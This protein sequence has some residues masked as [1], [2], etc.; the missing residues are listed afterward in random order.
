M[1]KILL[2][3]FFCGLL[4]LYSFPVFAQDKTI[5]GQVTGDGNKPLSDVTVTVKGTSA[6]TKTDANGYY[7]IKAPANAT[8]VFTFVD[9]QRSE[10]NV[11][12]RTTVNAAMTA[13]K[14]QM[15][16]VVVTALGISRN[17][18]ALASSSQTVSGTDLAESQ[19]ENVLTALAG[20]VAGVNITTT[21]GMPGASTG[22]ILRGAVS[23]DGNNQPLIIIDGLPTDN[24]TFSQ[25]NLVSDGP[26]RNND[27]TNRLADL[28]PNDIESITVLKGPEAT[29]L[30]G[31]GGA[32]GALI[33]TTRKAKAGKAALNYDY[34]FRGEKVYRFA[35]I[36]K[37]YGRGS[38]NVA[39]PLVRTFFGPKY[40]DTTKLYDN[41]EDF[42]K[43]G[44]TNKHNMSVE[45]G[46]EKISYRFS[47]NVINQEG[48][49]RETGYDRYS[50][51]L[52]GNAILSP[53]VE[54][55][56][57]LNY[58]NTKNA[59]ATK[60]QFGFL[61]G[62]YTWP[63][64][65]DVKNFLNPDGT[66]N[67]I[68]D[69]SA[70]EIDNP[71]WDA[72][73]NRSE[74][75]NNRFLGNTNLTYKAT[76]WLTLKSTIGIDQYTTNGFTVTHPQSRNGITPKGQL[77]N[78][79]EISRLIS[80]QFTGIVRKDFGNITNQLVAG[81]AFD[82][83]EYEVN[84]VSGTTF[85]LPDYVS[86]N[87]TDPI[88]QRSKQTLNRI[89]NVGWFGQLETGYKNYAF[90]T[91]SGRYDG[92][93]TLVRPGMTI[94]EKTENAFFFYPAVGLSFVFSEFTKS[95]NW[96]S[97]GKLRFSAGKTGK[98]TKTPYVT[99]SRYAPAQS[100]GGGF[101]LSVFGGNNLLKPEFTHNIEIGTEM[102]FLNNRI[103]LDFAYYRLKSVNQIV[104][105]RLSYA[106]GAILK[107]LNGG[108]VV[109]Q[110]VELTVTANP[111]KTNN[112][113]WDMI[114]NFDKN[115]NE[116]K[117]MPADLPIFY[118]SD[119][120]LVGFGGVKA[121]YQ[122][123]SSLSALGVEATGATKFQR[124]LQGKLII[125]PANGL[126]IRDTVPNLLGDRNPDFQMGIG[127]K[128]RFKNWSLNMNFD[129][130]RGGD[131]YNAN[132]AYL[133]IN[134]LG[135]RTLDRDQARVI[136]G[137]LRDGLENTANPTA[138]N[139]SI[140]PA[141]QN[142]FYNSQYN[143][144]D[145]IEKDISWIRLRDITLSYNLTPWLLKKQKVV[146]GGSVY[147]TATD[148]FLITNYTGADP[149]VSGLNASVGGYGAIG[150][151]YGALALPLGINVGVKV[152]F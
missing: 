65:D 73:K 60:G 140:T 55:Q 8:L 48:I 75:V 18:R 121:F 99:S 41:V 104:A 86:I 43:T 35:D 72:T 106:T 12:D 45:A 115:K 70:T 109:N 102:K 114:I 144:E 31:N 90:L 4:V 32:S 110:G 101:S 91:L 97:Y 57:T 113:N 93:S 150:Y 141:Y 134:G 62:L 22:I 94:D 46:S 63:S 88:T 44:I 68:D 59:K 78:F 77:E 122:V 14:K 124:N 51:R 47:A 61:L 107:Y 74:D 95:V 83:R 137:V 96:L 69:A 39:N 11:G 116:I 13:S 146:K 81:F 42:F 37:V 64:D 71:Y 23:M 50:F 129:I 56:T 38:A 34:D 76:D 151:D 108:E 148:V 26:N 80:G 40:A 139:I 135:T 25:G 92:A 58:V 120:D 85:Y 105:P 6:A 111:V 67:R 53:K 100:T 89:R 103:G 10:V 147:V 17:K 20:R 2:L 66:R 3:K 143:I 125:N 133:S 7:S 152:N 24:S 130:R 112:F 84:A 136:E 145:F 19:R 98:T 117:K 149:N 123:G 54:M 49:V 52:T 29:A 126:P 28:N 15:D 36:Q 9:Y 138:N 127:Q 119:Y 5:A 30:Y 131:I 79:T 21:T 118:I 142:G 132:E 27:Y 87:N 33:I 16:E 128:F 82:Q 1:R